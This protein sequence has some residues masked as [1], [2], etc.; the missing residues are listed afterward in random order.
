MSQPLPPLPQLQLLPLPYLG[1]TSSFPEVVCW[2]SPS[3]LVTLSTNMVG[4]IMFE[5]VSISC[6]AK[7]CADAVTTPFDH[8]SS[9]EREL[10]GWMPIDP[11]FFDNKMD[12]TKGT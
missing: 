8:A 12:C 11:I 4:V 7:F 1:I 2:T 5:G 9:C 6:L 3:L 10:Q